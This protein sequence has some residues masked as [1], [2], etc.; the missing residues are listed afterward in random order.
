[1]H[2][3]STADCKTDKADW[4]SRQLPVFLI[5]VCLFNPQIYFVKFS[6]VGKFYGGWLTVALKRWRLQYCPVL[7]DFIFLSGVMKTCIFSNS[8]TDNSIQVRSSYFLTHTRCHCSTMAHFPHRWAT[9]LTG[10]S[11]LTG[12]MQLYRHKSISVARSKLF[13]VLKNDR[14]SYP[15]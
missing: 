9:G 3:W 10:C 8:A 11:G 15:L 2:S 14:R 4:E 13:S 1:M 12:W 7:A 5:S 6:S